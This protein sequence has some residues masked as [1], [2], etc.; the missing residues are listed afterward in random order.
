M[1][2]KVDLL[3]YLLLEMQTSLQCRCVDLK[4][5]FPFH[6]SAVYSGKNQ[7]CKTYTDGNRRGME[8]I[9]RLGV[10]GKNLTLTEERPESPGDG[11]D[12]YR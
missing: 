2:L 6:T 4:F 5:R 10:D 7:F 3:I 9:P 11:W 1:F 8:E 12:I